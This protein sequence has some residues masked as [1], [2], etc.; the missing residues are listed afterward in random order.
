MKAN[1]S[2]E[3]HLKK[4]P[5]GEARWEAFSLLIHNSDKSQVCFCEMEALHQLQ[6]RVPQR[7]SCIWEGISESILRVPLIDKCL[8]MLA[9][10]TIR[11]CV[12]ESNRLI[13][14]SC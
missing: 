14:T 11:V 1:L 9:L 8:Y 2:T 10:I 7:L 13:N 12:L 3:D 5:E 4:K 6:N